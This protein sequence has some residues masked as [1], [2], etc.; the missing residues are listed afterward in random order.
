MEEDKI[1]FSDFKEV[2]KMGNNSFSGTI[3]NSNNI[4]ICCSNSYTVETI[5]YDKEYNFTCH[6]CGMGTTIEL[7]LSITE[8]E[9][10]LN[11]VKK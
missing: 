5:D 10:K 3:K 11:N 4:Y 7:D 2:E 6:R 8:L 9:D 1:K